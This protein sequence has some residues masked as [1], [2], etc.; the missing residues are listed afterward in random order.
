M[1]HLAQ[2]HASPG[3]LGNDSPKL[4]HSP[5]GSPTLRKRRAWPSLG[6][7]PRG[8][9][10]QPAP[11]ES[12]GMFPT[13]TMRTLALDATSTS[14]WVIASVALLAVVLIGLL[15]RNLRDRRRLAATTA[16]LSESES[17]LRRLA[18]SVPAGIFQTDAQG[19]RL[20]VNPKLVE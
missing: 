16:Q 19:R 18:E 15:Q 11:P 20:Y 4:P 3:Q 1:S 7:V 2:Y 6:R 17:R 8:W 14:S 9:T 13:T 10:T 12:D 5:S